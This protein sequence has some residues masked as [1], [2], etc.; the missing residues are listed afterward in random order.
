MDVQ[1]K[2]GAKLRQARD[3]QDRFAIE[4][5]AGALAIFAAPVPQ[6]GIPVHQRTRGWMGADYPP[7]G[8]LERVFG[9]EH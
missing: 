3:R 2:L 5:W 7:G 4:L 6:Y 8:P 9:F 1:D